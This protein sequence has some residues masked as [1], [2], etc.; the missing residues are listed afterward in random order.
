MRTKNNL[1]FHF[2]GDDYSIT[3]YMIS[4]LHN[5]LRRTKSLSVATI[6]RTIAFIY[7]QQAKKKEASAALSAHQSVCLFEL[8]P[9]YQ[10]LRKRE[11]QRESPFLV[12]S[13]AGKESKSSSSVYALQRSI[14]NLWSFNSIETL[15]FTS[16]N[17]RVTLGNWKINWVE[18]SLSNPSHV[19]ISR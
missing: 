17:F 11:K 7:Q 14:C 9:V 2:F 6:C 13:S 15:H 1:S 19:Q 10:C 4:C 12:L 8:R 3:F 5:A 16:K 18:I